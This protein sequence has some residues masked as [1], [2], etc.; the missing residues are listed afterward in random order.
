MKL[1]HHLIAAALVVVAALITL[2]ANLG[3]GVD[4]D[5]P[6]TDQRVA[7]VDYASNET[8]ALAPVVARWDRPLPRD[9]FDLQGEQRRVGLS[10]PPPPPPALAP[11]AP[12]L[13]AIGDVR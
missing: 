6:I 13:P 9:P 12:P 10:L 2:L 7:A 4:V 8:T 11:L 5:V 1:T 3:G